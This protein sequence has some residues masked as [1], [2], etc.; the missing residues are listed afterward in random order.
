VYNALPTKL[1]NKYLRTD[2]ELLDA[3]QFNVMQDQS[4]EPMDLAKDVVT[5]NVLSRMVP[6]K[7]ALLQYVMLTPKL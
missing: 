6:P 3:L 1:L 7:L 5:T 4:K 2:K